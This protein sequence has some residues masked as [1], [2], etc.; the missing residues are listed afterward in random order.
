[1]KEKDFLF[2]FFIFHNLN[3][4]LQTLETNN[5]FHPK[6]LHFKFNSDKIYLDDSQNFVMLR[7]CLDIHYTPDEI[8]FFLSEHWE[9]K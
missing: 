6:K 9:E 3:L 5:D 1:M 2:F 4:F 8:L 7:L